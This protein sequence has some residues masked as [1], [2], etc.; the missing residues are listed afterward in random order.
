[1]PIHPEEVLAALAHVKGSQ[2]EAFFKEFF[3]AVTGID[4]VPLG[5]M[6]DG[7]ADAFDGNPVYEGGKAGTFY[8]ASTESNHRKKIRETVSRLKK[9]GRTPRTLI[10]VTSR[11]V[12]RLD[13]DEQDLSEE[14]EVFTKIRDGEW[15]A[16]NVNRNPQA[17]AAY[18]NHLGHITTAIG[19]GVASRRNVQISANVEACVFMSYEVENG[20]GRL[21][22]LD[23]VVDSLIIWALEGTDPDKNIFLSRAEIFGKIVN[24][25]PFSRIFL[26]SALR[27]RLLVLSS[28]QDKSGREIRAYRSLDKYCLPFETRR[29]ID[30]EH[31]EIESLAYIVSEQLR[32]HALSLLN[33]FGSDYP[34]LQIVDIAMLALELTFRHEGLKLGILAAGDD[35]APEL[36]AVADYIDE[37]IRKSAIKGEDAYNAKAICLSMLRKMFYESTAEQ[38]HFLQ[39]LSRTYSLIFTLQ[40]EPKI[41]EYFQSMRGDFVLYVG[42]D[43]LVRAI[44]E[45]FLAETDRV[46]DNLLKILKQSGS[47]LFLTEFTLEEVWTHIRAA[48]REF[49]NHYADLEPYITPALASQIDRILIRA[50]FYASKTPSQGVVPPNGW[51]SYLDQFSSYANLHSVEGKDRL[52][53]YLCSRF[54][55]KFEDTEEARAAV[56]PGELDR[57]KQ[58]FLYLKPRPELAQNDALMVL[59]IYAKRRAHRER[60]RGNPFGFSTWWLTQESRIQAHIADIIGRHGGKCIIRPEFLM[61]YVSMS[62]KINDVDDTYKALFPSLF[63]VIIG[64]RVK[65][66]IVQSVFNTARRYLKYDSARVAVELEQFSNKLKSDQLKRYDAL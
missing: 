32:E 2:F 59:L 50:Y 17:Q 21:S 29:E 48:D 30:I 42:A 35:N 8:Q 63:G 16:N 56:D 20:R 53:T 22:L 23:A 7:G 65:P 25:F 54:G 31:A 13:I 12:R 49:E 3:S 58:R 36:S 24:T 47:T 5:G 34:A 46:T 28:K 66:E 11:I 41:I 43:I 4:F 15:V 10:Y 60:Y 51:K 33:E 62:P 14:L 39:L 55:L 9:T 1:M 6:A 38:R 61:Y 40:Y 45:T 27:D 26:K 18:T 57:L 64:T 19:L 37:S 52:R 44:S